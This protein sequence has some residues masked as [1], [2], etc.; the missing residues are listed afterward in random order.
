MDIHHTPQS[1]PPKQIIEGY[2]SNTAPSIALPREEYVNI[3]TKKGIVATTARR[4]LAKDIIDLRNNTNVGNESLIQL[5]QLNKT[6]YP[7][8]YK[9]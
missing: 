3:P 1:H 5:L 2:D 9:K 8:A 6:M 7:E 4:Q